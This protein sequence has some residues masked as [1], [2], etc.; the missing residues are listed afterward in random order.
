MSNDILEKLPDDYDL[1]SALKKYPMSY[2]Q[3]MNTVLIQEMGR[4]NKLLSYV[5]TSLENVIRAIKGSST[6]SFYI[7]SYYVSIFSYFYLQLYIGIVVMSF[8]LEDIYDAILMNKIPALWQQYSYP[9][10]KPLGGYVH[11]LLN[12]LNFFK[13]R[14]RFLQSIFLN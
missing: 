13:V 11:D 12:R 9:S 14:Y 2:E 1:V 6:F 3:S 4:F 10:L 8:E 5:K 7:F